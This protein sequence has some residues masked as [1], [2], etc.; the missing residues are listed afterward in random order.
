M[1]KCIAISV[2]VAALGLTAISESHAQGT[3]TCS[4]GRQSCM[5]TGGE[6]QVCQQR[7]QA[8]LQSG[9]WMGYQVQKCGYTPK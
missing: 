3:P 2:V 6:K 4:Q 8:C 5:R 1:A 7:Y 9:C